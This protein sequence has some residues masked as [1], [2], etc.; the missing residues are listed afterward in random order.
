MYVYKITNL[1]N[2]KIY[3]GITNNYKKRWA[4]ECSNFNDKSKMQVINYA[5]QKYKKENFKFEIL[6]SGLSIEEAS[7]KEIELIKKYNSLIPYG[8][9]VA[10][11]GMDNFKHN[12]KLGFENS[13]SKLT[14]EEAKYIKENRNKPEYILY[15]EFSNKISYET[16]KK[17]YNGITYTNIKTDVEPYP[18]NQAFSSQF[19][20]SPI[21]YGDVVELREKYNKGIYWKEAYKDYKHL[22]KNEW[23][24]W[25]LYYGN[26]FKLVMPEV[27]TEENKKLHSSLGKSGTNNGRAKLTEEDVINIRQLH[28]DG[29]TNKELYA[30]Y[31]QVTPTSIRDIINNKTW[32]NLL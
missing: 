27:F 17:C 10:K 24:F 3:I 26:T 9:N 13:N 32:K 4:N 23:S 6:F 28:K 1:I 20:S 19:N 14:Y 2:N 7:E 11:G 30:L 29:K 15:E 12:S 16:F 21:D 5:I 31:P 18:Y 25:N 22:Y 8:Y